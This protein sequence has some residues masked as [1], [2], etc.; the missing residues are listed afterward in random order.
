ML[1][2]IAPALFAGITGYG[3]ISGNSN[4]TSIG[5]SGQILYNA[6][7][8]GKSLYGSYLG[9][10]SA[11]VS[12]TGMLTGTLS[13]G[14]SN[15][16]YGNIFSGANIASGLG[17]VGGLV[18]LIGAQ[19]GNQKVVNAG[20]L[21]SAGSL[22]LTA[23]LGIAG[24]SAAG[25]GA[26]AGGAAA[27]GATAGVAGAAVAAV[28]YLAAIVLA[29]LSIYN[30]TQVSGGKFNNLS[31]GQRIGTRVGAYASPTGLLLG[32]ANL[33]IPKEY[34]AY[35]DP[36]GSYIGGLI[37]SLFGKPDVPHKVREARETREVY[38]GVNETLAQITQMRDMNALYGLLWDRRFRDGRGPSLTTTFVGDTDISSLST[39][40]AI[41]RMLANPE[42]ITASV[43]AGVN[44][45]L[46]VE[47]NTA[48]T[49]QIR[50]QVKFF[51]EQIAAVRKVY[52]QLGEAARN[53]RDSLGSLIDSLNDSPDAL[54]NAKDSL[55][56]LFEG[57]DTQIDIFHDNLLKETD[58]GRMLEM[59]QQFN[60][61]V[62]ER[63]LTE[64][65]AVKDI[66]GV[67]L[68][69]KN[70]VDQT[71]KVLRNSTLAPV[72]PGARYTQAS[73]GFAAAFSSFL[74]S[75]TPTTAGAVSEAA[76]LLLEAGQQVF[77]RPST[78]WQ[79]LF[80]DVTD[81]L[82]IVSDTLGGKISEVTDGM[83]FEEFMKKKQEE[84][85]SA[86]ETLH[87]DLGQVVALAER[88][89]SV[90][91][92]FAIVRDA[93]LV[94]A[95][96]ERQTAMEGTNRIVGA[97]NATTAAVNGLRP[98][99]TNNIGQVGPLG[100]DYPWPYQPTTY[101]PPYL[102]GGAT[103]ISYIPKDDL[104]YLHRE[105]AVLDRTEAEAWREGQRSD[106]G[107]NIIFE[108]G[109]VI[110]NGTS[111]DDAEEFIEKILARVRHDARFGEIGSVIR[112]RRG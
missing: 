9:P 73:S 16:N 112:G 88:G 96:M 82:Q 78:D 83:T 42:S 68:D 94:I 74:A 40:E 54:E 58:P 23:G 56:R 28:P 66:V 107:V 86:L 75:S 24:A 98:L 27:A 91:E 104:Y 19:T 80:T 103:G 34:S 8:I 10:T 39:Q 6:A 48:L 46:L 38:K 35:I 33:L 44:P 77:A 76:N 43:N 95:E 81:K 62:Q 11:F 90:E 97:V 26:A 65:A 79:N 51:N 47:A 89:V 101:Y 2:A 1:S 55:H 21:L 18:A 12:D 20:S 31:E 59:A 110:V 49:E 52:E 53:M 14:L 106:G 67:W 109:S 61:M 64:I 69:A 57:L 36:I 99:G 92:A 72:N 7:A 102:Q 108:P 93:E 41:Q 37:G 105:E 3:A 22:G 13:P 71:L 84:M 15:F 45:A 50:S 30:A 70:A 63:Y 32:P 29:A 111:D 85:V 87:A 17:I 100:P 25:A 4:M 5:A 60:Q